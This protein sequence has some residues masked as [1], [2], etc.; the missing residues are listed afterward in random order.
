MS[1]LTFASATDDD[2]FGSLKPIAKSD[3][4]KQETIAQQAIPIQKPKAQ[5]QLI[6]MNSGGSS[7]SGGLFSLGKVQEQAEVKTLNAKKLDINFD[8]D[9]FFNSFQPQPVM[10]PVPLKSAHSTK[11]QDVDD[12]FGI[13]PPQQKTKASYQPTPI[14]NSDVDV[15]EAQQRLRQMG[16]RK[17]ISSEEVFGKQE[18]KTEEVIQRYQQLAGAKAISSDMF[19]NKPEGG[20]SGEKNFGDDVEGY[21]MGRS[22]LNSN[23]SYDEVREA[24][25]K[26][27]ERVSEGAKQL[28]DKAFDWL[29]TF[30]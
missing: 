11:L 6:A 1:N 13:T 2:I 7:V 19:F 9:D 24:A 29:S 30:Q 10:Q 15:Q 28:K 27:A 25:T 26:I 5:P 17:C 4:R 22:S 20:G 23:N 21:I 14:D 12:P 3:E 8:G 18:K 16:N